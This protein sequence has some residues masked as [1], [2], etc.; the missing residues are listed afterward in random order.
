MKVLEDLLYFKGINLEIGILC[1]TFITILL[2]VVLNETPMSCPY[3]N[4]NDIELFPNPTN[5]SFSVANKEVENSCNITIRSI[6]GR[7]CS[8]YLLEAGERKLIQLNEKPGLYIVEVVGLSTSFT[9]KL[10]LK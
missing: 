2:I 8:Q 3:T 9:R 10:I 6:E 4:A 5:G 1:H 7:V